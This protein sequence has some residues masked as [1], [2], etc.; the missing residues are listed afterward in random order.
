[1]RSA[2]RACY[3][4]DGARMLRSVEEID[5]AL[6]LELG[7][8]RHCAHVAWIPRLQG[9]LARA[10]S[11]RARLVVGRRPLG[12]VLRQR[13]FGPP[14]GGLAAAPAA[15]EAPALARA[16]RL[17]GRGRTRGLANPSFLLRTLGTQLANHLALPRR[18]E[19][20]LGPLALQHRAAAHV[21]G[22]VLFKSAKLFAGLHDW[23]RARPLRPWPPPARRR[24]SP[25]APGER[26]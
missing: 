20:R 5:C 6:D 24:R 12:A 1:M 26:A 3:A 2:E 4:C 14:E 21:A 15:K 25:S 13:S 8:C 22:N 17:D 7:I 10:R 18:G 19:V 23:H 9:S 11:L 16:R